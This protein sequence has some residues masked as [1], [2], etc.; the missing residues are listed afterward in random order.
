MTKAQILADMNWWFARVSLDP[1][2]NGRA[3]VSACYS[4][5]T[6]YGKVWYTDDI[7]ASP[8]VWTEVLNDTSIVNTLTASGFS[9]VHPYDNNNRVL[10][11]V[12]LPSGRIVV[13]IYTRL[14]PATYTGST[15]SSAQAVWASSF[16][17]LLVSDDNGA[18]W[19][20]LP[21]TWDDNGTKRIAEV[22]QSGNISKGFPW[23]LEQLAGYVGAFDKLHP[24]NYGPSGIGQGCDYL[25]DFA[26]G[27][28]NHEP[29]SP[30][31]LS[32]GGPALALD[33]T[34]QILKSSSPPYSTWSTITVTNVDSIHPYPGIYKDGNNV[35]YY[36]RDNGNGVYAVYTFTYGGADPAL[37]II[38]NQDLFGV[39][40]TD[41][42][43]R[44][45]PVSAYTHK[46]VVA[47]LFRKD[48]DTSAL[49]WWIE[50]DSSTGVVTATDKTGNWPT[51][52]ALDEQNGQYKWGGGS[53]SSSMGGNVGF[54]FPE[55]AV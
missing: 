12:I 7:T 45:I 3:V 22:I 40:A 23:R 10:S 35:V 46:F 30:I 17:V 41:P 49:I 50:R 52:M 13:L 9:P 42:L 27:Q 5:N 19:N 47:N 20:A 11:S 36:I 51:A 21:L 48:W 16:G 44:P 43:S 37:E 6:Y 8:V 24:F 25:G 31:I 4:G 55:M 33:L 32:S 15:C 53:D 18:T 34:D 26:N 54:V 39:G 1:N 28:Q 29:L 14:D 2:N 38:S